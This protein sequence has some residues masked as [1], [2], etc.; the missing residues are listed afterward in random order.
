MTLK[1]SYKSTYPMKLILVMLMCLIAA[2]SAEQ[3]WRTFTSREGGKT[4]VGQLVSYKEEGELVTVRRK[5]NFRS[6][7]FKLSV[8]SEADREFVM[9]QAPA[10]IAAKAVRLTFDKSQEK[11]DDAKVRRY[12][13]CYDITV[14]NTSPSDLEDVVVDYVVIYQKGSLDKGSTIEFDQR[15]KTFSTLPGNMSEWLTTRGITIQS[16]SSRDKEACSGSS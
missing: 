7:S 16:A 15:S 2:A 5:D 3:D 8:L 10:L 13:G 4:F 14:E 9:E 1:Q 11:L 6:M 12:T